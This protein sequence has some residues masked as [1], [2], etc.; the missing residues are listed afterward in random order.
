[1]STQG[2]SPWRRRAILGAIYLVL[3]CADIS[4]SH[5][6]ELFGREQCDIVNT[7]FWYQRVVTLGYRKPRPHFVRVVTVAPP[8]DP[9]EYRALLAN[10]L[11]RI[12]NLRPMMIVLDYSFS[13]H[14]CGDKTQALRGSIQSVA[15]QIPVVFGVASSTMQEV[16]DKHTTELQPLKEAGF[17]SGDQAIWPSDVPA[18]GSATLMGLYRLDCDTRRVPT[19]WSVF[20][21]NN[22]RWAHDRK[23][24]RTVAIVAAMLYDPTLENRPELRS[25]EN[26]LTSFIPEKLFQPVRAAEILGDNAMS[27]DWHFQRRIVVVGDAMSDMHDSVVGR[28][29]G[30]VLQA[31]YIESL[32]DDRYFTG[33]SP[34]VATIA[35]FGCLLI[36]GGVFDKTISPHRA[37]FRTA[38]LSLLMVFISYVA[39]VHF[40][41]LF[42][43]WVPAILA[44]PI[45][46]VA[47]LHA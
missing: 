46:Y 5:W 34:I 7:R 47:K 19:D 8:Q 44:I 9:C 3:L 21:K 4:L 31:S 20:E 26:P 6:D 38:F 25:E 10:L 40:G 33:L 2:K 12:A 35:T 22:G 15:A 27:A 32:L 36:I 11:G 18:D 42:T 13:P 39:L 14:N 16:E 29:P 24:M 45:A 23:P 37:L 43:F 30:V 28:V 41:R 1:M 17:T